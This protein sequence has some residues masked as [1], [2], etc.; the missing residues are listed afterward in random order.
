MNCFDTIAAI[1]TP[2]G[3]GGVALIRISGESALAVADRI[4][5]V[6]LSE[7]K[8]NT[9]RYGKIYLPDASGE[10]R[11]IDDG[12]ATVFRAPCSFT[13]EDTVEICCHGGVL[14]TRT[15]LG[16]CLAAGARQAEA[17]EFT[18]RAFVNGKLSLDSSEALG[19]LLE[20]KTF[21]QLTLA[22]S[23][24]TGRLC[25]ESEELYGKLIEVSAELRA[26]I[27]F[28]DE[29]VSVMDRDTLYSV[30]KETLRRTEKL[31]STYTTGRAIAEGIPTVICGRTNSGKSSLYNR[32]VGYDAAIVTDIEGT[33]RD[34]LRDTV[35]LGGVTLRISDTAGLRETDDPVERIGVDRALSE[36]E[37]AGLVLA[38]VDGSREANEN[39]AEYFSKIKQ[40]GGYTVAVINKSDLGE[41]TKS[42]EKLCEGFDACVRISAKTGE[43]FA[44][45]EK[46]VCDAFIDGSVDTEN[47]AVVSNERQYG[48]LVLAA[49][50]LRQAITGLEHG[51]ETDLICSD[52]ERA[53]DSLAQ[54]G[55]RSVSEDIIAN[56]FSRFCVGK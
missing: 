21:S 48:A 46:C 42:A 13:G 41:H 27:D 47:D 31:A 26:D 29:D 4:F 37:G 33:T 1:S 39:D 53:M 35:S 51:Y 7:C 28:P 30:L 3:K 14:V 49:S 9:A 17:G 38:V 11:V 23:G 8:P 43:G 54:I 32:L 40:S 20:A 52:V 2:H 24:M 55:G 5:S 15:V 16:A 10:R 50:Q 18:R 45:L 34:I 22:R 44:A 6:K 56:I 12:I 25:R 19:A 36:I